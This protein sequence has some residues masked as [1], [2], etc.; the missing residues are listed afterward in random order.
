MIEYVQDGETA[1]YIASKRGH[2]GVVELLLQIE[3]TDVSISKKVYYIYICIN[4]LHALLIT[5]SGSI[6]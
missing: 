3:H 2:V 5:V 6:I 1:L 4:V